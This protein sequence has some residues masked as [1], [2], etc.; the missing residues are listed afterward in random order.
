[1][2][3]RLKKE[4]SSQLEQYDQRI[5]A[6][7]KAVKDEMDDHLTS[8]NENTEETQE[9]QDRVSEI[10]SKVDKL[11]EQVDEIH[12]MLSQLT[13]QNKKYELSDSEKRVFMVLYAVEL[14]PLSY[15]D[16]SMRTGLTELTVKAHIFSM[17]NKAIPILE[18]QIDGQSFF[19]LDKKFKELQAKENILQIDMEGF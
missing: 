1:M 12:L 3:D 10:E 7:F 14:T 18:R 4:D 17:I 9:I 2:F 8:I 16:I 13:A 6:A 11:K 5:R 15:A 19:R